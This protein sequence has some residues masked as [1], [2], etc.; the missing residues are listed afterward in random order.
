MRVF[1]LFLLN[2]FRFAPFFGYIPPSFTHHIIHFHPHIYPFFY[3]VLTN[4]MPI[5]LFSFTTYGFSPFVYILRLKFFTS[6]N[7]HSL[8]PHLT[9]SFSVPYSSINSPV[10]SYRDLSFTSLS[11]HSYTFSSSRL[12]GAVFFFMI[13]LTISLYTLSTPAMFCL[14]CDLSFDLGFFPS[15]LNFA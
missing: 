1:F 5:K 2:I 4:F 6:Q 3:S 14:L 8:V 13:C 10:L 7:L 9:I 11:R 12:F 15:S